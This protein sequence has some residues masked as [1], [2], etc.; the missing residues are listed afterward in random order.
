[1]AHPKING[2]T[3]PTSGSNRMHNR[4]M[5][6]VAI[7]LTLIT[8]PSA[9][10]ET[11]H[12]EKAIA[13]RV[14]EEILNQGRFELAPEL[15]A[16]DFVNHGFVRDYDLQEDMEAARGWK[17]AFPDGRVTVEKLLSD[18]DFII[19]LWRGEG[20]NTGIGNGLP[21][22]GRRFSGRG[23]TIWRIAGR[24]VREEWS[25]FDQSG[26]LLQLGL[27]APVSKG[28]EECRA[29]VCASTDGAVALDERDA[30]YQKA[31]SRAARCNSSSGHL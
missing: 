17:S 7:C 18:G 23:I 1:M 19:A 25:Q 12:E 26:I 31:R 28:Q 22:T 24:K 20:T 11:D 15:Y 21:A 14:V 29:A 3:P 4:L 8:T 5:S 6:T 30:T 9:G 10:A 16:E 13:L 2:T 27:L